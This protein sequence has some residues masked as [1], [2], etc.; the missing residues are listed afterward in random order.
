MFDFTLLLIIQ[1][2]WQPLRGLSHSVIMLVADTQSLYSSSSEQSS[3]V[4]SMQISA[5]CIVEK[6]LFDVIPLK[7]IFL[8]SWCGI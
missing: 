3:A 1:N 5:A 7:C 2:S 6:G 4:C 8:Y